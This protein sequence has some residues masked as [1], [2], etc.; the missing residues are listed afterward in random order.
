MSHIDGTGNIFLVHLLVGEC[1]RIVCAQPA[2]PPT[3]VLII[4]C[5]INRYKCLAIRRNVAKKYTSIYDWNKMFQQAFEELEGDLGGLIP[6]WCIPVEEFDNPEKIERIVP[7]YPLSSDREYY[8]RMNAVLSLYRLT[9]GQP[10]QEELITMFKNLTVEQTEKML[11]N[12]SPIKRSKEN[13]V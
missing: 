12:L 11:F 2:S 5:R 3:H 6:Y 10:R 13:M 4:L 7:M 9:M 1:Q 8:E